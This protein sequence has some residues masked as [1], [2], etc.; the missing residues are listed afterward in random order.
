[1]LN[2]YTV[3]S[4][5]IITGSFDK[6]AKIWDPETGSCLATLYGHTGEVVAAQFSSKGDHAAT[7]SM[8]HLA[9]LFDAETGRS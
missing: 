2:I 8:D 3:H 4:T 9:K 7:G 5:R 6:T 1:M